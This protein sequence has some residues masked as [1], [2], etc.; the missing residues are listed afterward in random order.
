MS[1]EEILRCTKTVSQGLEALKE[2]H[3]AIKTKLLTSVDVLSP[4][5]RQL[6]DEK[7]QI[8]DKNLENIVLG[9]GEAQ[10]IIIQRIE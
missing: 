6:I 5:E 7:T 10:V 4:D 9:M 3:D 2:E 1:Q 8:I